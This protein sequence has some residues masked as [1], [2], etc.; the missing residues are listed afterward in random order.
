MDEEQL[1]QFVRLPASSD[2][3]DT[4]CEAAATSLCVQEGPVGSA[5]QDENGQRERGAK[6]E[7]DHTQVR[8]RLA[9]ED[10]G[11]GRQGDESADDP[12]DLDRTDR[13]DLDGPQPV[14]PHRPKS[15]SDEDGRF[16]HRPRR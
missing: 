14:K 4:R 6:D 15:D 8:G 11:E 10:E 1:G 12:A 16:D 13:H 7:V 2:D 9:F 3:N 5:P